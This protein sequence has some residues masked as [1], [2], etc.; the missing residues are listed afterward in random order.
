MAACIAGVGC[1][2]QWAEEE[3]ARLAKARTNAESKGD[4]TRE[5][6]TSPVAA[7]TGARST[8][9]AIASAASAA[10]ES[11]IAG[12]QT[13]SAKSA[14]DDPSAVADE[15][16]QLDAKGSEL[17]LV[18]LKATGEH[19]VRFPS[20]KGH[21]TMRGQVPLGLTVEVETKALRADIEAFAT[22]LK[23][24]DFLD[25]ERF[26]IARF[27]STSMQ[28][29]S[30]KLHD[31]RIAGEMELHGKVVPLHFNAEIV[32]RKQ[33]LCGQAS[34]KLVAKS[35]DLAASR[36]ANELIDELELRLKLAFFRHSKVEGGGKK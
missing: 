31:Y 27:R 4:E 26:P 32:A 35:F 7:V 1:G 18:V 9:A 15:V 10:K 14:T 23:S 2:T 20:V 12:D 8:G 13:S 17:E 33:A 28:R 19:V 6:A 21:A 5:I 16:W 29:V 25:V 3:A 24:S 11:G 36:V 34:V 30:P 22:H